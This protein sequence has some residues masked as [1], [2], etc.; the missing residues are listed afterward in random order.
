MQRGIS[1]IAEFTVST[2]PSSSAN[3]VVTGS[4]FL[5]ELCRHVRPRHQIILGA[6]VPDSATLMQKI[7]DAY[8]HYS[9]IQSHLIFKPMGPTNPRRKHRYGGS[10]AYFEP[11]T[12]RSI[13]VRLKHGSNRRASTYKPYKQQQLQYAL[14]SFLSPQAPPAY[15]DVYRC[16][17]FHLRLTGLPPAMYLIPSTRHNS[18]NLLVVSALSLSVMPVYVSLW[19]IESVNADL[20]SYCRSLVFSRSRTG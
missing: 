20:V 2:L 4:C 9:S 19:L 6:I 10:I 14:S 15:G 13:S 1:T 7:E 3:C 18:P 11:P 16:S 8:C 5:D 12:G 17:K